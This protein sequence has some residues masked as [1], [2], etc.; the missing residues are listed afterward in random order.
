L[1]AELER[2]PV[3]ADLHHRGKDANAADG[4]LRAALERVLRQLP[5]PGGLAGTLLGA[6]ARPLL[7][8]PARVRGGIDGRR[9]QALRRGRRPSGDREAYLAVTT[10]WPRASSDAAAWATR[11]PSKN[12]GFCEPQRCTVLAKTKSRKWSGVM[13]PSSTSSYASGRGCRMSITSKWP[14]SEL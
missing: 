4:D 10:C 7:R 1:L 6:G 12:F 2:V 3:R 13:A 5:D 8:V 9:P 14:M 11:V